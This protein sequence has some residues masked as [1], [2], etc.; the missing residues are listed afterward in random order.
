MLGIPLSLHESD[1]IPGLANRVS[2][3]FATKIF[4]GFPEA[5]KFFDSKKTEVV[6]QILDPVFTQ[7]LMK[8]DLPKLPV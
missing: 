3:R 6:G 1:T 7:F 4:L 2:A 8:S 5:I